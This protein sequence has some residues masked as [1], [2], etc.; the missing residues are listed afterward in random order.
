MRNF[1]FIIVFF[2]I[3]IS[4]SPY[5]YVNK[6]SAASS[7]QFSYYDLWNEQK[8][9]Q[10]NKNLNYKFTFNKIDNKIHFDN[11]YLGINGYMNESWN[12]N[13]NNAYNF[14][15]FFKH[16]AR[17]DFYSEN[18]NYE[19]YITKSYIYG[20]T[21]DLLKKYTKVT[22]KKMEINDYIVNKVEYS[23]PKIN[24]INNDL[25]S[26]TY[27]F[28]ETEDSI[29]ILHLK[30]NL[31]R[32]EYYQDE[33]E[34][35]I[36]NFE[37]EKAFP[38]TYEENKKFAKN[39]KKTTYFSTAKGLLKVP[40][41]KI[42]LGAY[43]ET[44]YQFNKLRSDTK[45][46]PVVRAFYK[47]IVSNFDQEVWK[48]SEKGQI[49][50]VSMLFEIANNNNKNIM[51]ETI[52]GK[53]DLNIKSWALGTKLTK[54]DVLFRI[55][56]EMN[57]NWSKWGPG[58]NYN[59]SDL[60]QLAFLRVRNIFEKNNVKNAKFVFN[61]N[62]QSSPDLSWNDNV[63]Y[64]P[65]SNKTDFIGITAYNYGTRS[66]DKPQN[67][68][69]VYSPIYYEMSSKYPYKPMIIAEIGAVEDKYAPKSKFINDAYLVPQALFPSIKA[70]VWFD[71]DH[72]PY[73]L[74]F[75]SSKSSYEALKQLRYRKS[76]VSY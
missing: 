54:G 67:F 15:R 49:P 75:S 20:H 17:I 73:R 43:T 18:Y 33:L 59:D 63:M 21:L 31:L 12:Y 27:Y 61:P 68:K 13:F 3:I 39:Y 56:N 35:N 47:S 42:L 22:T 70:V 30:T 38:I 55:G 32:K 71:Q 72:L 16:D 25:N 9:E 11:P 76:I 28:I 8:K 51:S 48:F 44:D 64:Y 53:Y 1:N 58:N 37:F 23:R 34:R 60:Y 62:S 10:P 46:K 69:N 2:V 52:S 26:Y 41:G 65:G 74:R 7:S 5:N 29:K 19:K 45:G 57:G 24:T 4:I 14:M 36:L 66:K 40:T 6:V 50:M